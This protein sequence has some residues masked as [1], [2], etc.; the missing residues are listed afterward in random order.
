MLEGTFLD[1]YSMD[2]MISSFVI[3]V[4]IIIYINKNDKE[5]KNL[6]ESDR[7]EINTL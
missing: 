2:V 1:S 7:V 3:A 6:V 5:E 4:A